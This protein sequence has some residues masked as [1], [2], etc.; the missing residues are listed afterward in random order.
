MKQHYK[1]EPIPH[2]V[3]SPVEARRFRG[4]IFTIFSNLTVLI[5]YG[6]GLNISV[7]GTLALI[8]FSSMAI[9]QLI[10]CAVIGI[11]YNSKMWLIS[12]VVVFLTGGGVVLYTTF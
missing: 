11:T 8:V 2:R 12:A 4:S 7:D 9:L 6:I 3:V 10:I 5:I 1:Y